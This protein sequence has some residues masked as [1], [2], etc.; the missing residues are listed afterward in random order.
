MTLK[1][2]S[3]G[4]LAKKA[5]AINDKAIYKSMIKG[6]AEIWNTTI[7]SA[8]SARKMNLNWLSAQEKFL[9]FN[10]KI[11]IRETILEQPLSNAGRQE[12]QR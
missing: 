7:R 3:Y 5:R 4:L 2:E 11:S 10:A 1:G 9:N 12:R 8:A 6:M